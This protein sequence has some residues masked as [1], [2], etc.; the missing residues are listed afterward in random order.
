MIISIT[1][2]T[3]NK[4]THYNDIIMIM[5]LAI[6]NGNSNGYLIPVTFTITARNIG[7]KDKISYITNY[8]RDVKENANYNI[9]FNDNNN[10]I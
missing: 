4:D 5:I 9:T 3:A 8:E 6:M 7:H 2:T 10:I 1:T